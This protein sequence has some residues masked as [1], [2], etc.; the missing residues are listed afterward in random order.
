M[1]FPK[2]MVTC[3][4]YTFG[5]SLVYFPSVVITSNTLSHA[6][7]TSSALKIWTVLTNILASIALTWQWLIIFK[8]KALRPRALLLQMPLLVFTALAYSLATTMKEYYFNNHD[9]H[10]IY[11]Y[12]LIFFSLVCF[13]HGLLMVYALLGALYVFLFS[14]KAIWLIALQVFLLEGFLVYFTN[15]LFTGGLLGTS[16][17]LTLWIWI[18]FGMN[19]LFLLFASAVFLFRIALSAHGSDFSFYGMLITPS[20]IYWLLR[21]VVLISR[22]SS[23]FKAID[24]AHYIFLELILLAWTILIWLGFGIF[25]LRKKLRRWYIDTHL[26]V[27][28]HV[29]SPLLI[30]DYP[31]DDPVMPEDLVPESERKSIV[32]VR[33]SHCEKDDLCCICFAG[34]DKNKAIVAVKDCKHTFHRNCL[35]DWTAQDAR[36]PLCRAYLK[37]N[38][39]IDN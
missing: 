26:D 36:C 17:E 25:Q 37:A 23:T 1:S 22:N 28:D 27:S 38:N 34:F 13:E 3:L 11:T 12:S 24:Y 29:E 4:T 31:E 35:K 9:S 2:T 18:A 14:K 10:W 32:L 5:I 6:D 33:L 15:A 21:G 20:A 7:S 16:S 30:S 19:S 39:L 8:V